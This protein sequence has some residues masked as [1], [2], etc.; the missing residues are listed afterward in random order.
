M[1]ED[2]EKPVERN[3]PE[4]QPKRRRGLGTVYYQPG[5]K[6]A[7]IEYWDR[8]RRRRESCGSP[9]ESVAWSLL[10]RRMAELEVTGK[11]IGPRIEETT[12]LDCEKAL[13]RHFDQKG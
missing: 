9:R 4:P 2:T 3:G 7:F 5:S 11:V 8:G 10:R 13:I 6:N 1:S 12:Y